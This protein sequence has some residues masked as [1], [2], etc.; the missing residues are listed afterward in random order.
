MPDL[1]DGQSTQVKGS[2]SAIYTLKN[3]AGLYSCTCPAWMHQNVAIERRSCKHLRAYRGE[4]LETERVGAAGSAPRARPP[5]AVGEEDADSATVKEPPLL[6]AHKWEMDIDLAGWWMSEK[7]DGVRAY[8]DGERFFSRLGNQFH[9]P[10]WFKAGLPK[11]PLDGELWGG[12]KRFQ[13]TVGIVKRQDESEA[14]REIRYIVFDA[15]GEKGPFE[16]RLASC[17]EWLEGH[18]WASVHEHEPCRDHDHLREQLAFVESLGGE[19][20]MLRKPQSLY[21]AGRSSTLLKVKTFFDAEARVLEHVPGT[22]KHKGRLGSLLV[23]LADGT[24]FNVGTGFSDRE[25]EDPPPIGCLVTFRYQELSDGGVPRFPTFV[26][27]RDDVRLEPIRKPTATATASTTLPNE[28]REAPM[29]RYE[30]SEGSSN[31]FWEISLKGS[32]FI[33]RYGKIGTDGQETLKE[34]DSADKAKKE[35]EKLVAEKEKKGYV[36]VGGK[37]AAKV[38]TPAPAPAKA[39]A[40]KKA[41]PAPAPKAAPAKG[42]KGGAARRFEFVEGSSSKFWEIQ[43]EG[44]SFTTRYGK[45]GTD[46]QVTMKELDSEEKALREYEKLI[47]EKTKK[48]YEEV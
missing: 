11:K 21:E 7:L 19:G 29:A 14:W 45:I 18:E 43:L 13:R 38:K 28:E 47:A 44:A 1:E 33:T 36:L 22:G 31:K 32:S 48:G 27:I 12:R 9:V 40:P 24:R 4:A 25:R 42:K 35:Y 6:L 3:T 17:K 16:E 34:F 37:A 8:W 15:P 46:G 10:A 20:L 39:A 23:E 26:A 30:F 41:A 2:G 5:R